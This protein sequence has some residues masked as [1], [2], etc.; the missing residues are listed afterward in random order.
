MS[1]RHQGGK[2]YSVD[3]LALPDDVPPAVRLT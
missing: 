1:H 3:L 2:S